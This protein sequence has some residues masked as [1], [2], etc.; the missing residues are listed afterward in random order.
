MR[1]PTG[2]DNFVHPVPVMG[3]ASV[4]QLRPAAPAQETIPN[5]RAAVPESHANATTT[6]LRVDHDGSSSRAKCIA[7]L[8]PKPRG[9]SHELAASN[10]RCFQKSEIVIDLSRRRFRWEGESR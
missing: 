9:L 7:T 8:T 6:R 10:G 3:S 2:P 5:T 1:R 4:Y